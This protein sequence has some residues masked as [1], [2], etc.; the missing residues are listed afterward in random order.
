MFSWY[1]ALRILWNR[2]SFDVFSRIFTSRWSNSYLPTCI[3][4]LRFR[5]D[6]KS[7]IQKTITGNK[8]WINYF[9]TKTHYI[10][11]GS[12]LINIEK[13]SPR[14]DDLVI[15]KSF[16]IGETNISFLIKVHAPV[17]GKYII[18]FNRLSK[19]ASPSSKHKKKLPM[20]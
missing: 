18:F 5:R 17:K 9:Y 6:I 3:L 4:K 2:Y 19:S 14:Y 20:W 7:A 8:G 13:G 15:N 1:F 11:Q 10:K 12:K 16:E